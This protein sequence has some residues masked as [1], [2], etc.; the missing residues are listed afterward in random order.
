MPNLATK[1]NTR[2]DLEKLQPPPRK[3]QRF[4]HLRETKMQ[5][6]VTKGY[7]AAVIDLRCYGVSPNLLTP[8]A[9]SFRYVIRFV[10]IGETENLRKVAIAEQAGTEPI[11]NVVVQLSDSLSK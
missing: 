4:L 8:W 9:C 10:S 6:S 2:C 5:G 1:K 7:W 11:W 3:D